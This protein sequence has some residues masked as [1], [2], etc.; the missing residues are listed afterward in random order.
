[1]SNKFKKGDR[2]ILTS[3]EVIPTPSWPVWG[4]KHQCVGTIINTS[5]N[6]TW[7]LWDNGKSKMLL[8]YSLSHFTGVEENSL[9]PNVAFMLYK[10]R[11]N[12]NRR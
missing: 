2:V 5:N 9:S 11:R 12:E 3:E 7:V 8:Y 10:R 6:I 1:M 4:S